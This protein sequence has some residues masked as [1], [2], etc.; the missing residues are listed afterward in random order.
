MTDTDRNATMYQVCLMHSRTDRSLRMIVSRELDQFDITMMEWLLMEVVSGGPK[1]G[2]TMS[3]VAA[4]LDV[5]LP[6]V[7]ALTAS[8]TKAKLLKQ[9]VSRRDRRS[10]HLATTPTGHRLLQD[11]EKA[12]NG[13]M[14]KWVADIPKNQLDA[15]LK[16]IGLLATRKLQEA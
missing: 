13:T 11:M 5:T 14:D 8:L 3:A 16:T 2:M 9:K 12:V 15:Y 6:Q 7:T 1:E 10:R 4:A